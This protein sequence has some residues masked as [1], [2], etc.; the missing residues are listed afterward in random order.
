[1]KNLRTTEFKIK[2]NSNK[3]N[4]LFWTASEVM[5]NESVLWAHN[6][7]CKGLVI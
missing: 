3:F 4:E 2:V 7:G 6:I 1:M 5:G